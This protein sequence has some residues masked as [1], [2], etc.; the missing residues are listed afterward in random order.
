MT[1]LEAIVNRQ[2]YIRYSDFE[3]DKQKYIS[4]GAWDYFCSSALHNIQMMYDARRLLIHL[5]Y[6]DQIVS[7]ITAE[8]DT[9]FTPLPPLT[10]DPFVQEDNEQNI[11]Y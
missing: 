11:S 8:K 1:I 6:P 9:Y 10:D 3:L 5:I 7:A 2:P 4:Y